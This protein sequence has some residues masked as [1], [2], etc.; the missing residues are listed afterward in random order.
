MI[1]LCYLSFLSIVYRGLDRPLQ[2]RY[3]TYEFIDTRHLKWDKHERVWWPYIGIY[4]TCKLEKI[5]DLPVTIFN[6][7]ALI[8]VALRGMT[9][10]RN[11]SEVCGDLK[12]LPIEV[13]Y[14]WSKVH[15][16]IWLF[17]SLSHLRS[18]IL[19][20]LCKDE[21]IVKQTGWNAWANPY[22][23]DEDT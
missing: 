18:I 19:I 4:K 11:M 5:F 1:P 9:W 8:C 14:H 22:V 10:W 15:R 16:N 13:I 21:N 12:W 17:V 7:L 20:Q 6:Y 2:V 23:M 3:I